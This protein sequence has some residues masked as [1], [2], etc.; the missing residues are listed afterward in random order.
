M[1]EIGFVFIGKDK[2]V[3]RPLRELLPEVS[4][5]WFSDISFRMQEHR[6]WPIYFIDINT[7]E[8]KKSFQLEDGQIVFLISQESDLKSVSEFPANF[9][10]VLT[11]PIKKSQVLSLIKKAKELFDIYTDILHMTREISLEREILARKNA[12]LTFL[13]RILTRANECLDLEKIFQIAREELENILLTQG[14]GGVFWWEE[15][16]DEVQLFIPEGS[17]KSILAW[18]EFLLTTASRLKATEVKEFQ[19]NL[20]KLKDCKDFQQENVILVPLKSR[21]KTYGCMIVLSPK[22]GQLSKDQIQVLHSACNHL[23]LAMRNALRF[24]EVK[25]RADHDGLTGLFNRRHF[26]D[27]LR[28]EIK[29]HQR[30]GKKMAL[31]LL[32]IDF[33]KKINDK[34]GHLA[35]DMV[36]KCIAR[37]VQDAV[38]ETDVVARY[39]GEEFV[40]LLPETDEERAWVLAQRIR[41]KI[42]DSYFHL[43][44]KQ[45]K[46]TV[47]IGITSLTPGPLTSADKII[48][49]ADKALYLAKNSG[50]NMV[51]TSSEILYQELPN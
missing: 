34:Y 6:F 22:S 4:W 17:K 16:G 25:V 15:E 45:I 7:V 13:N 24:E 50:R 31:L 14:V 40:V 39:G 29:R 43:K 47:S 46:V 19:L 3:F 48:L 49:E 23:G 21:N 33:F 41:K 18:Q 35:G 36:L 27:V 42:E 10:G 26:D 8:A 51:C 37:L 38:R 1:Q 44:G 9:L 28:K 32:D 12:L 11:R 30:S 2:R 20:I 5:K